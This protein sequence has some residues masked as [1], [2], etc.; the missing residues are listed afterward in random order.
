MK[1]LIIIAV[2]FIFAG[3]LAEAKI[4]K[5]PHITAGNV[6][7]FDITEV[8]MGK[9]ETRLHIVADGSPDEQ[10]FIVD[11]TY[12][13]IDG[14]RYMMRKYEKAGEGRVSD[15]GYNYLQELDIWFEPIPMNATVFDLIE[16]DGGEGR[17][18][19]DVNL[20]GKKQEMPAILTAKELAEAEMPEFRLAM[21]SVTVNLH[22]LNY[23]PKMG[24]R[25][26]YYVNT[27]AGQI[28]NE[29]ELPVVEVDAEGNASFK[30][31]AK[32]TEEIIF[33]RVGENVLYASAMVAPGEKMDVWTDAEFSGYAAMW[34]RESLK[35]KRNWSISNGRY[36]VYDLACHNEKYY[37]ME[38]HTGEFADYHWTADGYT[39]HTIKAYTDSLAQINADRS[40]TPFQK[41]V[42]H[43]QLAADLI[44]AT[45][46]R[47]YFLKHNYWH[48]HQCYGEPVPADSIRADFNAEHTRRI[49]EKLD[50]NN[51]ALMFE[52]ISGNMATTIFKDAGVDD[53]Q[54]YKLAFFKEMYK[55]AGNAETLDPAKMER[56]EGLAVPFYTQVVMHHH[57]EMMAA[58][59]RYDT[60]RIMDV[61]DLADNDVFDHI[62]GQHKG[63][64]VVIDVWNTWCAPC[65]AAIKHHEPLKQTTLS[66][67]DIVWIYLANESSPKDVYVKMVQEIDGIHYRLSRSQ[68]SAVAKRFGIRFIPSYILV[69]REGNAAFREDMSD[70]EMYVKAILEKI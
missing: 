11:G 44:E 67:K 63:K 15:D 58:M 33:V 6:Y 60:K 49:A 41:K 4:V 14:R 28:N 51:P 3:L 42:A 24:K 36:R 52:A 37:G 39:E 57:N 50:I 35:E 40:M 46:N 64:V 61:A 9:T 66:N 69:D 29:D 21:D 22:I 7:R 27:L 25:V 70:D 16:G 65:R 19:W 47:D 17:K 1:R 62:I 43:N 48:V 10:I 59:E 38:L 8:E 5:W 30:L 68:S 55:E 26:R 20:T 53:G 45:V 23:R 31:L 32:G 34:Q 54:L 2:L 13:E 56:L 12:I 18:L